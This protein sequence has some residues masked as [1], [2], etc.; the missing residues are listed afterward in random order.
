MKND[1][2]GAELLYQLTTVI[3]DTFSRCAPEKISEHLAQA[4]FSIVLSG[5]D[6]DD[7]EKDIILTLRELREQNLL[8]QKLIARYDAYKRGQTE[9]IPPAEMY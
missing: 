4:A 3:S 6:V 2:K 7:P 5:G 8:L 9:E 1:D